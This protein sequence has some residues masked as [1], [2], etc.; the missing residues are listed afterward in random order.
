MA[1]DFDELDRQT[2]AILAKNLK[3]NSIDEFTLTQI[4]KEVTEESASELLNE[5]KKT[6]S[7]SLGNLRDEN[8]AFMDRN[9]ARWKAPLDL[10]TIF[11]ECA[12]ELGEAHS[13]AG[14]KDF[15]P[16]VF[17]MLALLH[18]RALLVSREI[19]CL[20]EGGFADG[21]LAR[22][23]TLHE[24]AVTAA[25]IR[26]HGAKVALA[27]KTSFSISKYKAARQY[28]D[29]QLRAG[30][31]PLDENLFL[32]IKEQYDAAVAYFGRKQEGDW[33]WAAE[34]FPNRKGIVR[35]SHIEADVELDHWR[36][37]YRMS[38]KHIHAE[39]RL[40]TDLLVVTSRK[41]VGLFPEQLGFQFVPVL[42]H[43]QGCL[44]AQG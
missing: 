23:R 44:C 2:Q 13:L 40:P 39:F 33:D 30:L 24:L 6:A 11:I 22:W 25:F 37:R 21:A 27:Y 31:T 16:A 26:K 32:V 17:E 34:A 12:T 18:P 29:F 15:D 19:I 20:L 28:R 42:H 43:L 1:I 7:S 8:A 36:P 38:S 14:P 35:F 41:V 3:H 4:V 10:L 5:I 9:Y